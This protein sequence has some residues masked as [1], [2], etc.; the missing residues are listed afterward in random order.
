[1]REK[2]MVVVVVVVVGG[3]LKRKGKVTS[4]STHL[5]AVK[6]AEKGVALVT[7]ALGCG[8]VRAERTVVGNHGDAVF[9]LVAVADH[10]VPRRG[11]A[12]SGVVEIQLGLERAGTE[13]HPA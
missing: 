10:G 4:H 6:D 3:L 1:M 5:V 11:D 13:V 9:L 8:K 12:E 2:V 7:G